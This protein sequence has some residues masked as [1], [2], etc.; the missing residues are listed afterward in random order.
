MQSPSLNEE[1]ELKQ[2]IKVEEEKAK[3]PKKIQQ[4]NDD[5]FSQAIRIYC[6]GKCK[7]YHGEGGWSYVINLN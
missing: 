3:T 2:G 6:E 1:Q 4:S 5:E 7:G